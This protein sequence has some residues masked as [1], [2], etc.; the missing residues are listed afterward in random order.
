MANPS[1]EAIARSHVAI[2]KN[3]VKHLES[4]LENLQ[5]ENL[6]LRDD[7]ASEVEESANDWK[8]LENQQNFH[9][10]EVLDLR[11][12]LQGSIEAYE[13]AAADNV[14]QLGTINEARQAL[15]KQLE[16]TQADLQVAL[17]EVSRLKLELAET[18]RRLERLRRERKRA[19]MPACSHAETPLQP[20]MNPT[21]PPPVA[22]PR[23]R[24]SPVQAPSP[25]TI[26]D[27]AGF[28]M[29]YT[30]DKHVSE[31]GMGNLKADCDFCTGCQRF[32]KI[33]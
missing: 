13:Q 9:E 23:P 7:Q 8:R 1:P 10:T 20:R 26:R 11:K 17:D 18:T 33:P 15:R 19:S 27:Q 22:P 12:A 16:E 29:K 6:R 14:K 2:L 32:S 24:Q 30:F 28:I 31:H 3:N 5:A 21:E 25:A 4:K